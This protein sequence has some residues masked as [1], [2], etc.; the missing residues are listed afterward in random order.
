MISASV[1]DNPAAIVDVASFGEIGIIAGRRGPN[2]LPSLLP[3]GAVSPSR[4][5]PGAP[6]VIETNRNGGGMLALRGRMV[7]AHDF[8]TGIERGHAPHLQA[9]GAGYIDTGFPCRA[10][11]EARAL[12]VT[13]P[14]AGMT[15]TG[16]YRFRQSDIEDLVAQADPEATIIAVPDGDLGQRLAGSAIDR[17][18]L[19]SDLQARGVNPLISGAFKARGAAEAA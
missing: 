12:R 2:N 10:D 4:R 5:V 16:G 8:A 13:A 14:P 19:R 3:I 15:V 9:D 6:I 7:P 18:V 17:A 11:H 1:W